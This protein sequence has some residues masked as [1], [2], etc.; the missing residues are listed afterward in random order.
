MRKSILTT[1]YSSLS[2]WSHRFLFYYFWFFNTKKI[3][4]IT[5]F[6]ILILV[7]LKT[8]LW[9]ICLIN[10]KLRNTWYII[11][12]CYLSYSF[13]IG[14]IQDLF[15]FTWLLFII[16]IFPYFII[17]NLRINFINLDLFLSLTRCWLYILHINKNF[18]FLITIFNL[19]FSD[20][21]S[22]FKRLPRP[23]IRNHRSQW[24]RIL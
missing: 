14:F 13:K 24:P 19:S 1:H 23:W 8:C 9:L 18:F 12:F 3:L 21:W 5:I 16:D 4:I 22:F 10:L 17:S 7:I 15:L 6:F 20:L 2:E 11:F